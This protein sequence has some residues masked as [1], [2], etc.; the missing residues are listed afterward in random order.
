MSK[1]QKA[2]QGAASAQTEF[3]RMNGAQKC[4]H[5]LKVCLFFLSF[6]FAYPNILSD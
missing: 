5:V 6:G 3:S 1:Q 4:G 2:A